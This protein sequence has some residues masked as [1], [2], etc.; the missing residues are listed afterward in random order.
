MDKMLNR[1]FDKVVEG[2]F[3]QPGMRSEQWWSNRTMFNFYKN[4]SPVE[5]RRVS[6]SSCLAM[7][8]SEWAMTVCCC[9]HSRTMRCTML[10]STDNSTKS[11]S[12]LWITSSLT[13]RNEQCLIIH[14]NM[15]LY[16][17]CSNSLLTFSTTRCKGRHL[18]KGVFGSGHGFPHL[19]TEKVG[20]NVHKMCE[21]YKSFDI[22]EL[23]NTS[24]LYRQLVTTTNKKWAWAHFHRF[25]CFST[26]T[27]SCHYQS[28]R[29]STMGIVS[30]S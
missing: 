18:I 26:S 1:H 16:H 17:H 20:N 28:P 29:T 23:D 2:G 24:Y 27:R 5:R 7:K 4:L 19:T 8:C 21:M 14:L 3:N 9:I 6:V 22:F 15:N 25:V 10:K 13:R 12:C 30:P 11:W